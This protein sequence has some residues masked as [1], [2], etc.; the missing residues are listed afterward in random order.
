MVERQNLIKIG[1]LARKANV[2]P[3]KIRFYLQGGLLE[4][5]DRTNGGYYLFEEK[6]ALA[7]LK[8][9]KKLQKDERLRLHEIRERLNSEDSN[10]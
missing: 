5:A 7:R 6:Y 2:L 10:N 4:V 3:S 8:L 9:I 1:R